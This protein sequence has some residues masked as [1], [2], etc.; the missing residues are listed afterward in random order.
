MSDE[1]ITQH[2]VTSCQIRFPT[3]VPVRSVVNCNE[4]VTHRGNA[5]QT[6]Y[7]T[8]VNHRIPHPIL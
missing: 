2:T 1:E 5:S 6:R 7:I 8:P 4:L 3:F